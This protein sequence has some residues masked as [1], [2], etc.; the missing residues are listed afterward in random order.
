[1]P[2]RSGISLTLARAPF[3]PA[4]ITRSAISRLLPYENP[5][6][7]HHQQPLLQESP[8]HPI[9]GTAYVMMT[10]AVVSKLLRMHLEMHRVFEP[11]P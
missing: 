11:S 9:E 7:V 2:V 3:P 1:M 10:A 4:T 6:V 5:A 8:C